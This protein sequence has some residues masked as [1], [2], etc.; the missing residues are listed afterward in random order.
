MDGSKVNVRMDKKRIEEATVLFRVGERDE[1]DLKLMMSSYTV[2]TME[3]AQALSSLRSCVVEE[4]WDEVGKLLVFWNPSDVRED[5]PE[6]E[7]RLYSLFW[8]I[9]IFIYMRRH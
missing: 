3:A 5:K 8:T 2:S 6:L 4:D 7:V 9:I 1:N